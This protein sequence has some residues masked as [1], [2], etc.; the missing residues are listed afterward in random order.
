[1][2]GTVHL[3]RSNFRAKCLAHGHN[4]RPGGSGIRTANFSHWKTCST[5]WAKHQVQSFSCVHYCSSSNHMTSFFTPL[6]NMYCTNKSKFPSYT[7]YN[8]IMVYI[9][10]VVS[11]AAMVS[12]CLLHAW[13]MKCIKWP[14]MKWWLDRVTAERVSRRQLGPRTQEEARNEI[15][16]DGFMYIECCKYQ[17][18]INDS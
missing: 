1:M 14:W 8:Y 6:T 5:Y 3:V 11:T 12:L 9:Y 10:W 18:W 13:E 15:R 4:K 16:M 7:V 17:V 2:G